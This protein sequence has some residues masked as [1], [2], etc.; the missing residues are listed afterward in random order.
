MERGDG[1]QLPSPMSSLEVP[2]IKW[3]NRQTPQQQEDMRP[4]SQ[5]AD[6]DALLDFMDKTEQ[7]EDVFHLFEDQKPLFLTT[8]WHQKRK[9]IEQTIIGSKGH[10]YNTLLSM[11]GIP[12]VNLEDGRIVRG[13]AVMQ[14]ESIKKTGWELCFMSEPTDPG[15]TI[16]QTAQQIRESFLAATAQE[17]DSTE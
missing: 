17:P 9:E 14:P 6:Y 4:E 8:Q 3:P 1:P 15:K 12:V 11:D 7:L 16:R 10:I 2:H 13:R 5:K